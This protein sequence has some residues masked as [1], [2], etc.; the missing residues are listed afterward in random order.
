ML[1]ISI[2][3]IWL[4]LCLSHHLVILFIRVLQLLGLELRFL[5]HFSF[6]STH[7]LNIF[8]GLI[9]SLS[10]LIHVR[11][12][13][14]FIAGIH[15]MDLGLIVI[16]VL[17]FFIWIVLRIILAIESSDHLT[18][19]NIYGI[20]SQLC[21]ES[22]SIIVVDASIILINLLNFIVVFLFVLVLL[23]LTIMAIHT[24]RRMSILSKI[25]THFLLM[26]LLLGREV[27]H[28]NVMVWIHS[29]LVLIQVFIISILL[30][31]QWCTFLW[32][33]IC[34]I[35]ILRVI[36]VDVAWIWH[37]I[38]LMGLTIDIFEFLSCEWSLLIQISWHS[39]WRW[40]L[41]MM[42]STIH[43]FSIRSIF[44]SV[45]RT[46]AHIIGLTSILRMELGIFW[47]RKVL[48]IIVRLTH[49]TEF[50]FLRMS[51]YKRIY[52]YLFNVLGTL[53]IQPK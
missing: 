8:L 12:R 37:F 36:W 51:T 53:I 42:S 39:F 10:H 43:N 30:N 41:M 17:I 2:F 20:S 25:D 35:S 23:F 16:D 47:S 48:L 52:L 26:S 22:L 33:V 50:S 32:M 15:L 46:L 44:I 31:I 28:I 38:I 11:R 7:V 18:V 13:A 9:L 34:P 40:V 29:C 6:F 14:L 45:C 4:L 49:G 5:C 19:V 27:W 1:V 21:V 3:F 24:L